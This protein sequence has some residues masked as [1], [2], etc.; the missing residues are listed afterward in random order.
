MRPIHRNRL[1]IS[2]T[3]DVLIVMTADSAR[4]TTQTAA[5]ADESFLIYQP[6]QGH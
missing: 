4:W 6:A 2:E 5:I 1:V 3:D